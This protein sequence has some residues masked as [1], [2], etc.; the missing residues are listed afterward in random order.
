MAKALFP[1]TFD[2]VHLGHMRVIESASSIFD[3][4]T[5][6]LAINPH[7][8]KRP[9][10]TFEDRL[11]MLRE[12]T[13]GLGNVRCDRTDGEMAHYAT[14]R[15]CTVIVRGIRDAHDLAAEL[16]LVEINRSLAPQV[17]TIFFPQHSATSS[18]RIKELLE[19]EKDIS[20]LCPEPV[21]RRLRA[22]R[23]SQ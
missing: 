3:E 7:K 23:T 12:S 21:A 20:A 17:T 2:P 1:G 13:E 10:F 6:L 16:A 5:V 9:M 19:L 22:R 11:Q 18:T 8:T 14:E 15:G 4:L